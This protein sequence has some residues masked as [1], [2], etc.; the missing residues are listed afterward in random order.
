MTYS[1]D[2]QVTVLQETVTST[3]GKLIRELGN[4]GKEHIQFMSIEKF[5]EYIER[6][7]LTA[8]PHRGCHW[9]RVLKWAEFFALQISG[10]SNAI[11]NFVLSSQKA[12]KLMWTCCHSLIEVSVV[13]ATCVPLLKYQSLDKIM[14]V[15]FQRPSASSMSSDSPFRLYCATTISYMPMQMSAGRLVMPLTICSP[16]SATLV[17][18]TIP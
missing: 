12:A 8:M 5:L 6:Q 18:T 3:S 7:R 14:P 15:P 13:P 11:E 4:I 9:D 10:Y 17:F 16:L 2:Q 1:Q